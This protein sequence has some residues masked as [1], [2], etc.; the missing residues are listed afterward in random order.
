MCSSAQRHPTSA[1][2]IGKGCVNHC[3]KHLPHGSTSD[4]PGSVCAKQKY[5]HLW[6][7]MAFCCA[8]IVPVRT[9]SACG[10][11]GLSPLNAK[12]S[13]PSW[14]LEAVVPATGMMRERRPT[15]DVD[16]RRFRS[17]HR[18]TSFFQRRRCYDMT[19]KLSYTMTVTK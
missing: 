7:I 17:P 8:S 11:R 3:A 16:L 10:M 4:P 15:K 1:P 14:L 6:S 2:A 5:R 9:T 12:T 13:A 18:R 19:T